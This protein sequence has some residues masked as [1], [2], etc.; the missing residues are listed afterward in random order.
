M[1]EVLVKVFLRKIGNS[2]G[3]TFPKQ[4]RESL[5]LQVGQVIDL[6][7]TEAGLLLKPS[8]KKYKLADLMAENAE[9]A[10]VPKDI[11]AWQHMPSVGKEI[12]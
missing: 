9:N 1:M 7:M 12:L 2:I 5:N 3:V 10:A 4:L 11:L 6:E 8:R